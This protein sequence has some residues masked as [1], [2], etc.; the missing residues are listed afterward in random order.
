MLDAPG[1]MVC[2]VLVSPKQNTQ[3]RVA[4]RQLPD[5]R[6][7]SA[8]MEELFPFLDPEEQRELMFVSPPEEIS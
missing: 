5:G 7:V 2:K 4:S 8:P 3:P 6:M 1:P